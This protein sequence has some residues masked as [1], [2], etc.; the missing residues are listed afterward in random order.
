M[1]DLKAKATGFAVVTDGVLDVRTITDNRRDTAKCA[2]MFRGVLLLPC[3]KPGC[4]CI[5]RAM[6]RHAPQ[7]EL[8]EVKIEVVGN[9]R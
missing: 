2:L 4:D 7:S 5:E 1:I 3:D 8:V 9:G 6:K